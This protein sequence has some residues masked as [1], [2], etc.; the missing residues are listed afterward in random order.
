METTLRPE[1]H[2]A[3]TKL[4]DDKKFGFPLRVLIAILIILALF[5]GLYAWYYWAL[6]D[7]TERLY[8]MNVALTSGIAR[9]T[10]LD[11]ALGMSAK[12][13]AATGDLKYEK[14][15]RHYQPELELLI[16]GTMNT[17]APID[18]ALQI[19]VTERASRR[20]MQME[21]KAFKLVR[22]DKQ[23]EALAFLSSPE[24][25]RQ[26]DLYSRG[27]QAASLT[28]GTVQRKSQTE[29]QR[30]RV[31]LL[32]LGLSA[33]T[34]IFLAS[35]FSLRTSRQWKIERTKGEQA[36][37]ETET[38]YRFV[39]G[40]ANDAVWDWDLSTNRVRW[41]EGVRSLFGYATKEVGLSVDWWHERIH[42]EDRTK[43]V[44]GI[45]AVIGNGKQIWSDE[46]RFKRHDGSYALVVDRGYV[47]RDEQGKPVRMVGAIL[48]ITER[49]Q[50]EAEH[51]QIEMERRKLSLAVEQSPSIAM[52]TDTRGVIEYVNP[53]F[54][55]ITGYAPEDVIGKTPNI[56]KSSETP[57]EVFKELWETITT[58]GEWRGEFRN[59]KKNGELYW[60]YA[61]ISS[62]KNSDGAITHFLAVKEDI[63]KRKWSEETIIHMAYFDPLTDLPNRILFNDRL[64][65]ALRKRQPIAIFLIGLDR[66]KIINDTLGHAIGDSMLQEVAKRLE[67]CAREGAT[68]ARMGGDEFML[69][70][71]GAFA[72]EEAPKV[73]QEI[74]EVIKPPFI[75][76]NQELHITASVG[77]SL[78]PYDGEDAETLLKNADTALNRVKEQ[79]K[80]NYQLYTPT[81]NSEAFGRMILENNM[82]KALEREEFIIHYQAQ[83][84]LRSG[85][86]IGVEALVRWQHPD[87]GLIPPADFIPM[88][89]ENGLIV[90]IGEW[91]LR[92][93]CVQ[94]KIWQEAG[95]PPLRV[96]VNLS[97][98]Q[99]QQVQL[100]EIIEQTLN[101]TRLDSRYLELEI[102][103]SIAMQ[104]ADF[105]I[106]TLREFRDMG[107]HV[108][109]DDFGTGY[110]SLSYLRK[111]PIDSLK[112]DRSFIRDIIMHPNDAAIITAVIMLAHSLKVKVTAEGV[113]TQEQL[114]FLKKQN[115][116]KMQGYLFSRPVPAKEFEE[117][118]RQG[119]HL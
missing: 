50:I 61:S 45:E 8:K 64:S 54:T 57:P 116:D 76:N 17:M 106:R 109:I 16:K 24:Y 104:N 111:F 97:A 85:R 72:V 22:E 84:D 69:L 51:K 87:L 55:E 105:T 6:H 33:A 115:C 71:P 102:T 100:S 81:M 118:I 113:E 91:V 119:K 11:E 78:Y 63:T 18:P 80:N 86:I 114:D 41:N 75:F 89:E 38:R 9:I 66:F 65:Q 14:R 68:V 90:P 59:R 56:L 32:C 103:E 101:Q 39:A 58:G 99:F 82:L 23:P 20:L 40:A 1:I 93:A 52:I 31:F 19:Q 108:A 37:L 47:V 2:F 4:W 7:R 79:G 74:I 92:T 107:V 36:L 53:K 30:Y 44:S 25:V 62:I 60:E 3:D 15:Y 83:V 73:A 21:D 42:P 34:V 98:R 70:L 117:L 110:S 77:I 112:I 95:L 96:A 49:K 12:M 27:I 28:L 10:F 67:G 35:V 48:D 29:E 5:F 13:T 46:Y 88:A 43:V 26:K 94:N